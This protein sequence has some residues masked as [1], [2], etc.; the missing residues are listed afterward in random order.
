MRRRSKNPD[1]KRSYQLGGRVRYTSDL[2]GKST[3]LNMRFSLTDPDGEG[4]N[5]LFPSDEHT[6]RLILD[7]KRLVNCYFLPPINE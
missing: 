1:K 4:Y 2:R 5:A 3:G 6:N 7:I